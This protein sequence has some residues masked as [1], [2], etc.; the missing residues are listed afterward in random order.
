MMAAVPQ[1]LFEML[2]QDFQLSRRPRV[3]LDPLLNEG[4]CFPESLS[5]PGQN[6]TEGGH[7]DTCRHSEGSQS[8]PGSDG[9]RQ[10]Q[11]AQTAWILQQDNGHKHAAEAPEEW[12]RNGFWSPSPDVN[13]LVISNLLWCVLGLQR[14]YSI[15][16]GPRKEQWKG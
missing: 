15:K 1:W 5:S 11:L 10:D 16:G 3:Q 12:F 14:S 8:F 7:P 6:K 13:A 4:G 2:Q 9:C